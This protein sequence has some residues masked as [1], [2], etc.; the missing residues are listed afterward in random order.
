[1]VKTLKTGGVAQQVEHLSASMKPSS[2][3]ST[4]KKRRKRKRNVICQAS[5]ACSGYFGEGVP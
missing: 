5:V 2:N 1:M 3:P 4:A